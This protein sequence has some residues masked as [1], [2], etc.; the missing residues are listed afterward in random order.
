MEV[1]D[2]VM[3]KFMSSLNMKI[4]VV[5]QTPWTR[6]DKKY[7]CNY[8]IITKDEK[9]IKE[10]EICHRRM[11]DDELKYVEDPEFLVVQLYG[12]MF[13]YLGAKEV[14]KNLI[15]FSKR[16]TQRLLDAKFFDA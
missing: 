10:L 13:A 3:K 14:A 4:V 11:H 2:A 15:D 9:I 12:T 1:T 16:Y 8:L 6:E 5:P 7:Y